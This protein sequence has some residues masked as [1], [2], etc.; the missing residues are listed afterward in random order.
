MKEYFLDV[1]INFLILKIPGLEK[2]TS[3]G[4]L[5]KTFGCQ[6]TTYG[7]RI[8]LLHSALELKMLSVILFF[9]KDVK[10]SIILA[11]EAVLKRDIMQIQF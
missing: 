1:L 8:F 7:W 2:D 5:I 4:Y 3:S 10:Q 11:K 6:C 9:L